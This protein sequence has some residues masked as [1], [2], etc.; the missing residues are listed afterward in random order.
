M[1][2]LQSWNVNQHNCLQLAGRC[3]LM[4]KR[5][6]SESVKLPVEF[7]AISRRQLRRGAS[8][9]LPN[10]EVMG[11]VGEAWLVRLPV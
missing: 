10:L 5:T 1:E 8:G 2:P 7:P 11:A 4:R 9:F 6:Y 3:L